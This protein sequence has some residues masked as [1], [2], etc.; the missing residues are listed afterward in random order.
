MSHMTNHDIENFFKCPRV[1]TVGDT[2]EFCNDKCANIK[3]IL[4]LV[5]KDIIPVGFG[6]FIPMQLTYFV[7]GLNLN[8]TQ[9]RSK[10]PSK[11]RDIKRNLHETI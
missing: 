10:L 5:L 7:T 9:N 1:H 2:M 4:I 8:P 6:N 3:W 11:R